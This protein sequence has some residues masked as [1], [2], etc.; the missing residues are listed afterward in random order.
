MATTVFTGA[1][2]EALNG[3]LPRYDSQTNTARVTFRQQGAGISLRVTGTDLV[4]TGGFGATSPYLLY[5]DGVLQTDPTSA[6]GSMTVYTGLSDTA[7]TVELVLKVGQSATSNYLTAATGFSVTGSTPAIAANPQKGPARLAQAGY[8]I[9]STMLPDTGVAQSGQ[10]EIGFAGYQFAPPLT[11]G[12]FQGCSLRLRG[13]AD[14]VWVLTDTTNA[15]TPYALAKDGVILS[16]T[17]VTANGPGWYQIGASGLDDGSN[18]DWEVI[19]GIGRRVDA[20]MLGGSSAAVSATPPAVR[21]GVLCL[22]DS[23]T[24]SV[25]SGG[26][27]GVGTG[28][29]GTL[30]Y[31]CLLAKLAGKDGLAMGRAGT[32]SQVGAEQCANDLEHAM[33][34]FRGSPSHIVILYGRNDTAI[35][36][37]ATQ[38]HHTTM[39]TRLLG[40]SRFTGKIVVVTNPQIGSFNNATAL[41]IN[42]GK[43]DAVTA[44]SS[45]RVVLVEGSSWP[46]AASD[47]THF[48]IAGH[49][50]FAQ[51]IY[52]S[53][54]MGDLP[55]AGYPSDDEIAQAVWQ[56]SRRTLTG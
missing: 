43:R 54:A 41:A 15:A 29:D 26:G 23:I 24:A 20:I 56:Y 52:D 5:L 42:Q 33:L 55:P 28:G 25:D 27:A 19:G 4:I 45:S 49:A 16:R 2:I 40:N 53:G 13:R 47:G 46:I 18:H 32:T 14:R 7:R 35:G 36:G 6:A 50:D 9:A 11:S 22:G 48:D 1:Q 10:P 44:A 8:Q 12:T 21:S 31:P 37:S 39:L 3:F 30:A 34:A 51:R 38:T 17:S